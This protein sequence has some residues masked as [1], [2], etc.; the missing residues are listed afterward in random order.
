[1]SIYEEQADDDQTFSGKQ[2][3][4]KHADMLVGRHSV[5]ISE[6]VDTTVTSQA[7]TNQE[8]RET[9][10]DRSQP[11]MAGWLS[12]LPVA[13]SYCR[14]SSRSCALHRLVCRRVAKL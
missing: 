8:L 11:F 10:L 5:G 13:A 2:S 4:A 1:M 6:S 14:T 3:K 9:A 12:L 7:Y